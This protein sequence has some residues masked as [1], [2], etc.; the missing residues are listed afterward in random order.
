MQNI[1]KEN[2]FVVSGFRHCRSKVRI[3]HPYQS[4]EAIGSFVLMELR[5]KDYV[6]TFN[7]LL[8]WSERFLKNSVLMGL[9]IGFFRKINKS[10]KNGGKNADK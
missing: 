7:R 5:I 10:S 4:L 1:E 2:I 9:W 3:M 6:S 8:Q